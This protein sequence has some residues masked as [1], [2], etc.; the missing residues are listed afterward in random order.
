MVADSRAFGVSVGIY[1]AIAVGCLLFFGVFR[2]SKIC[3]KFYAPKR[4]E[5]AQSFYTCLRRLQE[6]Y[7][8]LVSVGL[9]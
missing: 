9:M 3:K 6:R 2:K 7:I 5:R 4:Y 1:T 8:V